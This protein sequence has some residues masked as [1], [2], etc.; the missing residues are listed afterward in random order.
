MCDGWIPVEHFME[1]LPSKNADSIYSALIAEDYDNGSELTE[2][3]VWFFR[4][5]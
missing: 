2:C 5:G 3:G 4:R 1:I